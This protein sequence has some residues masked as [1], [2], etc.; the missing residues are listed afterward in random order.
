MVRLNIKPKLM[1][2]NNCTHA[3]KN[4]TPSKNWVGKAK[5]CRRFLWKQGAGSP[6]SRFQR[7]RPRLPLPNLLRAWNCGA[8]KYNVRGKRITS[9]RVKP[10]NGKCLYRPT[11]CVKLRTGKRITSNRVKRLAARPKRPAHCASEAS[12]IDAKASLGRKKNRR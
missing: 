9:N 2:G 12:I 10:I 8:R 3:P 11:R 6:A 5:P 7:K 1:R 4:P